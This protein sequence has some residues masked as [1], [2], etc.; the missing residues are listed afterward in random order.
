MTEKQLLKKLDIPDWR[1]LSKDKVAM[2]ASNINILDPEVARAV[3]AQ[4]PKFSETSLELVQGMQD[5]FKTS[6]ST[7]KEIDTIALQ[8]IQTLAERLE[9]QLPTASD[10]LKPQYIDAIIKL[11][12]MEKDISESHKKFQIISFRNLAILGGGVI[13]GIAASLGVST[14]LRNNNI[15]SDDTDDDSDCIDV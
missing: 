5:S 8:D 6:I 10:E 1:H 4:I 2:F 14:S 12:S 9:E 11:A 13:L 3:L 15:S 7:V